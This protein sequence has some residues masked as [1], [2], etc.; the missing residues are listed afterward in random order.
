MSLVEVSSVSSVSSD[1]ESFVDL[2]DDDL[3]KS[4]NQID[5]VESVAETQGLP[6]T[7]TKGPADDILDVSLQ[8]NI[9]NK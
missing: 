9:A 4:V 7:A 8:H 6:A 1:D 3:V 5:V 2:L